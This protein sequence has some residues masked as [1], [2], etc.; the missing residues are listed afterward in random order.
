MDR[1]TGKVR[2]MIQ[3]GYNCLE[4]VHSNR[5][6][7]FD[8]YICD[9]E[10]K[11]H[12]LNLTS[13]W[14]FEHT[15]HIIPNHC[16]YVHQHSMIVKKC[17]PFKIE[18]VVRGYITG[19]TKTSLWTH[20]NQ[21][22]RVYCG[23]S[24]PDG[25]V[26]NQKLD[27][28]VLTPTTKGEVDEPISAEEIVSKGYMTHEQW[29]TVSLAA[30]ALFEYGQRVADEKGYILVDTKYEFGLDSS[31]QI[32]LIDEIHTCDS[33][34]YWIKQ[35]YDALFRLGKEPEKID[36]DMI[37]DYVKTQCD[38]YTIE[39]IPPIPEELKNQVSRSYISF[40]ERLTG[41]IMDGWYNYEPGTL[42]NHYFEH[43]LKKHAV[44]IAG[45]VK[46]QP[47]VDR[48]HEALKQQGIYTKT[49]V[50]SAH[51][52]TLKL[53]NLLKTY[54]S[55]KIIYITVA[56]RSNALSGVVACNSKFPVIACPPFKDKLDMM[57]NL[58]STLQMPSHVPVMTILEPGN[59]AE[60]V[61]RIFDLL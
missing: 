12:C 9:V 58:H 5:L 2:D 36:K 17:T 31:G 10:W 18:V 53:L 15:R 57:V 28:P 6:S 23:I 42:A 56:G 51:K 32:L 20:Y 39:I 43:I 21:G 40:Y 26:K 60:A 24:F 52:Q 41:Y 19:S 48:I 4:M 7:S 22:E 54:T 55:K 38:P 27:T 14:W 13:A 37:R 16:L 61:Q 8:R 3:S 44:I 30:L 49:H 1:Y 46:D 50:A 11:G 47:F 45:S 35:S 33:S 34:R 25:L 29:G 59:V